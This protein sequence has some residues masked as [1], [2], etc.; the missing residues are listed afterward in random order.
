MGILSILGMGKAAGDAISSPIEAIGNVFD[1]LFT[2]DE[3][4]A[5][6]AAVMEKIKQHPQELQAEINK[7]EA[8]HGSVFVAGWRP[9]I[10]WICGVS[11]GAWYIPQF[12]IA[13]FLWARHCLLTNTLQSYPINDVDGLLELVLAMLGMAALRTVDKLNRVAR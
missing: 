10:G 11:L 6:A 2:S 12:V 1:K 9:F 8:Q 7:L 13:A 4:R 3:E 5:A